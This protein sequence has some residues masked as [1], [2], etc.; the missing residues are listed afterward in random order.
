MAQMAGKRERGVERWHHYHM[1]AK[2]ASP[3]CSR[4]CRARAWFDLP[5]CLL[6]EAAA[7]RHHAPASRCALLDVTKIDFRPARS[8]PPLNLDSTT[9]LPKVC[10]SSHSLGPDEP[11]DGKAKS[12]EREIGFAKRAPAP[13]L[14][15]VLRKPPDA[16]LW[17]HLCPLFASPALPFNV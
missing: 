15:M 10:V 11:K 9:A 16:L 17:P 12:D 13:A 8:L 1:P 2:R 4:A 6:S 7:R 5:S 14:L 3:L